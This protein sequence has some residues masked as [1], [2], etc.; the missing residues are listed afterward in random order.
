MMH[1][2]FQYANETRAIEEY[3]FDVS[4]T[5]Y[6]GT[7]PHN[8]A[9][10]VWGQGAAHATWWTANPE[11]IH[12]IN[13]LPITGGS[14]YLGRNPAYVSANYNEIVSENSGTEVEWRDIIW[15][16]QAFQDPA[17]AVSKFGSDAYTPEDGET[18]A[19]S[20]AS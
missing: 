9:G 6:P 7:F 20:K 5:V 16:F 18:K 17:A 1:A 15:S 19:G 10:M 13:F 4:N 2:T 11:E 8:A 14:L 3:W 12:G